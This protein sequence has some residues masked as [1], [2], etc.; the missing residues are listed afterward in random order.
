MIFFILFQ[1][2]PASLEADP[3]E[4]AITLATLIST[5]SALCPIPMGEFDYYAFSI[6]NN[7]RNFSHAA[8]LALY[9]SRCAT[10]DPENC[11]QV[12]R[13]SWCT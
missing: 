3:G 4:P 12:E 5:G 13:V 8:I 7:G 2:D 10:F 1:G 9:D 11:V 6:S